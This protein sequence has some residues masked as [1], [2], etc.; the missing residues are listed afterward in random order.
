MAV[1]LSSLQSLAHTEESLQFPLVIKKDELA[2]RLGISLDP[3]VVLIGSG[4]ENYARCYFYGE[5]GI[6]LSFSEPYLLRHRRRGFTLQSLCM[7]MVSG[8]KF[9]PDT[10]ERLPTF[11]A[12][13][14]ADIRRRRDAG[15]TDFRDLMSVE[16]PI[17][18]PVCFASGVPL[19][20]CKMYY[21]P[22]SGARLSDEETE[23]HIQVGL[24][25]D[26]LMRE[27]IDR[28]DFCQLGMQDLTTCNQVE[29][30]GGSPDLPHPVLNPDQLEKARGYL[31]PEGFE[32][33][34]LPVLEILGDK[35]PPDPA[36]RRIKNSRVT[37]YDVSPALPNG[38]GYALGVRGTSRKLVKRPD[39]SIVFYVEAPLEFASTEE[40]DAALGG[41]DASSFTWDAL[42][43]ALGWDCEEEDEDNCE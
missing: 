29:Y 15:E 38:F 20:G 31:A 5:D 3:D 12:G 10:G 14:Y 7:A 8:V 9:D 32:I 2:S 16:M 21:D 18:P 11:V 42:W 34:N 17:D 4:I 33:L 36:I 35:D 30:W 40:A 43:A 6:K 37:F 28:G 27:R 13:D 25:L 39:G 23:R 1:A 26:K 22:W 19:S 24:L 41:E